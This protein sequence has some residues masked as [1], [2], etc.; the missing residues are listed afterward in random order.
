MVNDE[1][2]DT[3]LG[4]VPQPCSDLQLQIANRPVVPNDEVW[5]RRRHLRHVSGQRAYSW[6]LDANDNPAE[7]ADGLRLIREANRFLDDLSAVPKD[8]LSAS[9]PQ[10]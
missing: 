8:G 2:T 6:P 3:D 7:F 10:I 1:L 5:L 4:R 9:S